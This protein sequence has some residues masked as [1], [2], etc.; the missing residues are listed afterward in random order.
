MKKYAATIALGVLAAL[1]LAVGIGMTVNFEK[2]LAAQRSAAEASAMC[3]RRNLSGNAP[4][5]E[6]AR[7]ESERAGRSSAARKSCTCEVRT[8]NSKRRSCRFEIQDRP[9]PWPPTAIG[10]SSTAKSS[11]RN[12]GRSTPIGSA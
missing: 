5:V 10:L 11:R 8:A 3:A 9:P 7:R 4:I 6:G 12:W 2:Q 1:I